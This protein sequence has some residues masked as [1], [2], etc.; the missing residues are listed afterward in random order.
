MFIAGVLIPARLLVNG[1]TITEATDVDLIH[2]VHLEL[3]SHDIL[4]ANGAPSES[5]VD[6]DSRGMFQNEAE[7]AAL[8][9]NDPGQR[10]TFCAP[11]IEDGH[12]LEDIRAE[13]A[14]RAGLAPPTTPRTG[15]LLGYLDTVTLDVV[16][17]WAWQPDHPNE[18][19]RLG[20]L[21]DGGLVA[22]VVAN[23]ERSDVRKAGF[24]NG[25]CGFHLTLARPLSPF[26]EHVV[27]VRRLVD[28]KALTHSPQVLKAAPLLD[29]AA[30]E[31]LA[32]AIRG[33]A[34]GASAAEMEALLGV[35]VDGAD[36]LLQARARQLTQPVA[37][38]RRRRTKA[39][40]PAIAG[41]P[42]ALVIDDR[43]PTPDQDAGSGAVLDHMRSL[44]RLGYRVG[45]APRDM[46]VKGKSSRTLDRAG[47]LRL[48]APYYAGVED[49]LRQ[50]A[51]DVALVYVHRV[52]NMALYGEMVRHYCPKAQLVYSVAD[53][54]FLRQARQEAIQGEPT[55]RSRRLREK[56]LAA[57][58]LA[59]AVI[60]HSTHEATLL[61]HL[62]PGHQR[63]YRAVVGRGPRPGQGVRPSRRGGVH[64][65]LR[66]PP[67]PRCRGLSG[68]G[69]V[70]P[71]RFGAGLKGKVLQS[72]AAGIPCVCTTIAAEG[73][74]LPENLAGL[75]G[76][77]ARELATLIVR[78]HGDAAENAR[79]GVREEPVAAPHHRRPHEGC[80]DAPDAARR[81]QSVSTS[82]RL[83]PTVLR[84]G[85]MR[86]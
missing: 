61:G 27:E 30:R 56:E 36:R 46:V 81:W 6:C 5:F 67:Q 60:T 57:A 82:P 44:V 83:I 11:R 25:R 37:A 43:M 42:L 68:A 80:R 1:A 9:P 77:D 45:F 39:T 47:I 19:V 69:A 40:A 20:V 70:A 3:A 21:V 31:A 53:L 29:A 16:R 65:R 55:A 13:L 8:Y 58:R 79:Y 63:P 35:L 24:G 33:H 66:P 4:L 22:L 54:H 75:V 7:Y 86:R 52:A 32:A 15:T 12:R 41:G 26:R 76:H 28:G 50:H 85:V 14:A 23:R 2:Y 51:G 17:G 62:L 84:C 78:L 38:K 74:G 73:M 64:R 49:V 10:W 18:A 72:L 34:A 71:L 48:G 59:D